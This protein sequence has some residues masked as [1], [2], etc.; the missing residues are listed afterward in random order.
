[1]KV[2]PLP[3]NMIVKLESLYKDTGLIKVPERYKKAPHLIGRIVALSMR[4]DDKRT[5]GVDLQPGNRIIVTPLGGRRLSED[6]WV[7]PI[8][9]ARKDERGK[10]YRDSGVLAIVPDSVD[11]SAHSQDIERCQ[12]CGDVNGS[13][14]NMLMAD[15]ICPRCGKN[16]HGEIPDN[17]MKV[18]DAEV[19]E[20]KEEQKKAS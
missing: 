8:S 6:T 16:S 4:L 1:M 11:M 7:Y 12:F 9:L 10:K 17:S 20:F 3:G 14:Q 19:E 5:L 2:K 15:G 13:K 18:T